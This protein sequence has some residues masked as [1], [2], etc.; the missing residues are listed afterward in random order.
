MPPEV[1]SR[2]FGLSSNKFNFHPKGWK[3]HAEETALAKAWHDKFLC[4]SWDLGT[5]EDRGQGR[6]E[7]ENRKRE[8]D[9][10][11]DSCKDLA[12]SLQPVSAP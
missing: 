7:G 5:R 12:W 4:C 6:G 10:L 9:G 3:F 11:V 2:I 1:I 8:A